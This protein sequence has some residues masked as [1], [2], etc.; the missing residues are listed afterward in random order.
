MKKIIYISSI[1]LIFFLLGFIYNSKENKNIIT[2]KKYDILTVTFDELITINGI[3]KSKANKILSYRNDIGFNKKEDLM[4]VDGIGEKT[5]K[6]IEKYFYISNKKITLK[7]NKINLNIANK[8]ELMSLPGIGEKNSDK[9]INYRKIKHFDNIDDLKK[10]GLSK[11]TINNLR[12][13]IEF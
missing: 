9:I 7:N 4:K 8:N 5:Y 1:I 13:L 12:G 11:N 2:V 10:I 3:G 6:N